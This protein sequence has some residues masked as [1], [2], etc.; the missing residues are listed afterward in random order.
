LDFE[1]NKDT[2]FLLAPIS[3]VPPQTH[4]VKRSKSIPDALLLSSFVKQAS[5][6]SNHSDASC[7]HTVDYAKEA[8]LFRTFKSGAPT[9]SERRHFIQYD[10]DQDDEDEDEDAEDTD[11][12]DDGSLKKRARCI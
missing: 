6:S 4:T 5:F 9:R 2:S 7:E 12:T 1:Q 11:D 8:T 10:F 3:S